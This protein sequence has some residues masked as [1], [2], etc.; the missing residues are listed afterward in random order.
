MWGPRPTEFWVGGT[1]TKL[2]KIQQVWGKHRPQPLSQAPAD[3]V[4]L[5]YLSPSDSSHAALLARGPLGLP[6][7][8]NTAAGTELRPPQGWQLSAQKSTSLPS[9]LANPQGNPP[10]TMISLY[11]AKKKKKKLALKTCV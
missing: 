1:P 11:P 3:A 10:G 8:H 6:S 2:W 5:P 4:W 9:T 7:S